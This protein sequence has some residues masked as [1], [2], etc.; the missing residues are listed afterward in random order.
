V[1]RR[2]LQKSIPRLSIFRGSSKQPFSL[3]SRNVNHRLGKVTGIL[4]TV[5]QHHVSEDTE[6]AR[7][8]ALVS[9]DMTSWLSH[10][11]ETRQYRL[12]HDADVFRVL[13]K[14]DR[15]P[16]LSSRLMSCRA[17]FHVVKHGDA[18]GFDG[19]LRPSQAD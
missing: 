16:V 17:S 7:I 13:F 6:G 4:S 18:A 9:S 5:R 1:Q 15:A 19:G 12:L 11:S 10:R 14:P 2:R 8:L 3:W